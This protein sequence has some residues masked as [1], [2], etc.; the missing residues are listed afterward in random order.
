MLHSRECG[1][2]KTGLVGYCNNVEEVGFTVPEASAE[3][4]TVS[5]RYRWKINDL[6]Q[7]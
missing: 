2:C 6:L 1:Y 7:V 5:E 4:V 3:Y